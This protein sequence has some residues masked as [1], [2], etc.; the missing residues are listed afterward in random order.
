MSV[1]QLSADSLRISLADVLEVIPLLLRVSH[2]ILTEIEIGGSRKV[3]LENAEET[4]GMI[5]AYEID[6]TSSNAVVQA[7]HMAV[8]PEHPHAWSNVY[9]GL[10]PI[11]EER[12]LNKKTEAATTTWPR[13]MN[14]I[15]QLPPFSAAA[16]SGF[17]N[18]S[19][20]PSPSI[21]P[22][23]VAATPSYR[24]QLHPPSTVHHFFQ[25]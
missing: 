12:S 14:C 25:S 23:P 18:I 9:P 16:S 7:H 3:D 24:V 10:F 8:A 13:K 15:S 22:P 19:S 4:V 2:G 1:E 6:H 11:S 5:T 20:I 17:S 21:Q